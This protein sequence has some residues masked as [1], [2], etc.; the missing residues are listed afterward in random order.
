MELNN[1]Q[2]YNRL[3]IISKDDSCNIYT[4]A[5]LVNGGLG[6]KKTIS[7]DTLNAN[8]L[9]ITSTT[10][11]NLVP[12]DEDSNIGKTTDRF[13]N[14]YTN[15]IDTNNAY[16]NCCLVANSIKTNTI[17][18]SKTADLGSDENCKPLIKVTD[19]DIHLNSLIRYKYQNENVCCAK[20]N[21]YPKASLILINTNKC[22]TIT[23]MKK[24]NSLCSCNLPDGTFVKIYNKSNCSITINSIKIDANNCIEFL[25]VT[26]CWLS[27][28]KSKCTTNNNCTTD[29]STS[30]FTV[31]NSD[32]L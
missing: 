32:C 26:N 18:S 6:V 14:I 3:K 21:L 30:L 20:Y 9:K 5:L 16:V 11:D 7:C 13:N 12:K 15:K 25:F 24:K 1:D 4:G 27:L 22:A 10:F 29:C 23:L 2:A 19:D 17:Q 31:H 28:N 8:N